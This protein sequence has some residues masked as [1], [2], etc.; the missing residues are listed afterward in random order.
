MSD[1]ILVFEEK[2]MIST[3]LYLVGHDGCSKT[4]LYRAVSN[5][6]RMPQKLDILE[7]SGLIR[8][9]SSSES[10]SVRLHLT[11]AGKAVGSDLIGISNILK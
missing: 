4:E 8:Q 9:E 6:P 10:R 3:M 5:N 2:H 7:E 11:E 1:R